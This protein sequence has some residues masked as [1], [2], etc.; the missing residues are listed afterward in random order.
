MM[1]NKGIQASPAA[2]ADCTKAYRL[3]PTKNATAPAGG[4]TSRKIANTFMMIAMRWLDDT[5]VLHPIQQTPCALIPAAPGPSLFARFAAEGAAV[6]PDC[7]NANQY[8]TTSR[9][10][11]PVTAQ[12]LTREQP[13]SA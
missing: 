11:I 9:C 4:P 2:S 12:P 10:R 6:L 7:P 5:Q 1:P 8:R 3:M 13:C